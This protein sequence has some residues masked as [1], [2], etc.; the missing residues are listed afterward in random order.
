M[1]GYTPLMMVVVNIHILFY[2][3][4]DYVSG[5]LP[6]TAC[7]GKICWPR[8]L[9]PK[10]IKSLIFSFFFLVF[11]PKLVKYL[12]DHSGIG[13]ERFFPVFISRFDYSWVSV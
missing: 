9:D 8:Y 4:L 2:S 10:F 3:I 1:A 7:L 6:K 11:R 12:S 5:L 13:L